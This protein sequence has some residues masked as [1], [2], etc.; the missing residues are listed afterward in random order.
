MLSSASEIGYA[1][2]IPANKVKRRIMKVRILTVVHLDSHF[3]AQKW[4]AYVKL[5]W[6]I[7]NRLVY[8]LAATWASKS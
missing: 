8:V 1:K 6:W 5:L 4:D 7:R 3:K 2:A